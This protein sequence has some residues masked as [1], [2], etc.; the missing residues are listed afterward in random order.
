MTPSAGTLHLV[1]EICGEILGI[2]RPP[3]AASFLDLGGTSIVAAQIASRLTDQLAVS[4][5]GAEI[6]DCGTLFELASYL[7]T[8]SSVNRSAARDERPPA[9]TDLS[10][11][12][13]QFVSQMRA[14]GDANVICV[15]SVTGHSFPYRHFTER[16]PKRFAV[17]GVRA[18]PF[19]LGA[20]EPVSLAQMT[21]RYAS[22]VS[23]LVK[24]KPTVIYGF[25]IGGLVAIELARQLTAQGA[26][27]R[28]LVIADATY[29]IYPPL[30][31]Q[32]QRLTRGAWLI[33]V[34]ALINRERSIQLERDD[35]FW[36]KS[37]DE[38]L[39]QISELCDGSSGILLPRGAGAAAVTRI[40]N[41]Y[42]RYLQ[43]LEAFRPTKYAGRALVIN[44]PDVSEFVS[45]QAI[46]VSIDAPHHELFSGKSTTLIVNRIVAALGECAI[47][48]RSRA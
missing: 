24:E 17:Y 45:R 1:E 23:S 36:V 6:L 25:C 11:M 7:D 46:A 19:L 16:L 44:S 12:R 18:I 9:R 41:A 30:L 37:T 35:S 43:A 48:S 32:G 20:I 38:R 29:P 13:G 42:C 2:E 10:R 34:L 39:Q 33:F 31:D 26:Q 22:E 15:H 28:L 14:G 4:V 27:P 47:E 40:F 3:L 5:T 8:R 21:A